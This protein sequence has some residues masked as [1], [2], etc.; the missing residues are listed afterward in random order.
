[1]LVVIVWLYVVQ[2]NE[3]VCIFGF[4]GKFFDLVF[5]IDLLKF[6]YKWVQILGYEG[7]FL[8]QMIFLLID[9]VLIVFCII[10]Q[11]VGGD[12]LVI[13]VGM[14]GMVFVSWLCEGYD[15]FLIGGMDQVIF[16]MV[17]E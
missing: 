17:V 11:I 15:Y 2:I 3:L 14:E 12:V 7:K 8:V 6:E 13:F 10:C 1:M 9:G 5:L 16:K 4:L